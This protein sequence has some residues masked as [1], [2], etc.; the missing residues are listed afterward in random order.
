M[1]ARSTVSNALAPLKASSE[2]NPPSP[3]SPSRLEARVTT[4]R[5]LRSTKA[6][7]AREETRLSEAYRKRR[8]ESGLSQEGESE[9]RRLLSRWRTRRRDRPEKAEGE[10]CNTGKHLLR[11]VNVGEFMLRCT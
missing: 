8:L 3:S 5:S 9:D 1:C 7:G 6:E 11:A 4:R 2:P 10:I